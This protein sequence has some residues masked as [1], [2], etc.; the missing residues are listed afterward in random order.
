MLKNFALRIIAKISRVIENQDIIHFIYI[1]DFAFYFSVFNSIE[2]NEKEFLKNFLISMNKEESRNRIFDSDM[3]MK[4][5]ES[6][7]LTLQ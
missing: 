1:I 2:P 4:R 7:L 3:L 6:H 5:I